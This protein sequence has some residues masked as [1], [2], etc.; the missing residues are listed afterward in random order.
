[1]S[2]FVLELTILGL[3]G[4]MW[5]DGEVLV[6]TNKTLRGSIS[7][8]LMRRVLLLQQTYVMGVGV[9]VEVAGDVVGGAAEVALEVGDSEAAQ[10][11]VEDMEEE[12]DLEG[13]EVVTAVLAPDH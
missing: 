13:L 10:V 8:G 12:A 3:P 4:A 11:E 1:M 5:R 2:S 9:A 6:K 7:P